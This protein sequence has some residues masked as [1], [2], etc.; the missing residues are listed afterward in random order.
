MKRKKRRGLLAVL[1]LLFL[2]AGFCG[3]MAYREL[4]P[5]V[6]A[7]RFYQEVRSLAFEAEETA[8]EIG[9]DNS[10]KHAVRGAPDWEALRNLNPD[11]CGWIYGPGTVIDYPIVQGP[12]NDYYLTRTVNGGN[13]I[14]G[15]IFLESGNSRDFTDDV[16][17]LY[18]H[19]IRGGRMF[20]SLSGYKRKGYYEQHPD[21]YLYLPEETF[22]IRLFAGNVISGYG[23]FPLRFAGQKERQSWLDSIIAASTFASGIRPQAADRILVL[24]TCSYEYQNARYAVYGI[25]EEMEPE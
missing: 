25:M 1:G 11:I 21:L 16:S 23:S 18:G 6:E 20:S 7:E 8:A 4:K 3:I 19:H 12:D 2:A 13:S 14:A 5:R 24:C 15:S 22:R 9:Q 17:V 10:E